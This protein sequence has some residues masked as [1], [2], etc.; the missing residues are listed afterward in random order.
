[1]PMECL[2]TEIVASRSQQMLLVSQQ[3]VLFS[4]RCVNAD[5]ESPQ[6]LLPFAV[7]SHLDERNLQVE[8]CAYYFHDVDSRGH[9]TLDGSSRV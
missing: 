4:L 2:L 1:M 3:L 6:D 8:C 9:R 7:A 5:K